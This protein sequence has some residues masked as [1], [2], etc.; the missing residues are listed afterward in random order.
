MRNKYVTYIQIETVHIISTRRYICYVFSHCL[1]FFLARALFF[2]NSFVF[3]E[4]SNEAIRFR[5]T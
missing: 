1:S 5:H 3:W 4:M 2:Y